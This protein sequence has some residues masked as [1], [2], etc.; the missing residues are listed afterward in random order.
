VAKQGMGLSP[1]YVVKYGHGNDAG[2]ATAYNSMKQ[3]LRLNPR[4]DGVF[5]CDDPIAMGALR[6]ILDA[7]LQIPRDVAVVG[8]GNVHYDDL[9][10]VPLTSIDQDSNGL[11]AAP[12]NWCSTFSSAKPR[13][14]PRLC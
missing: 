12:P 9:L 1:E 2:D 5:C 6:A 7:G 4:P 13:Q 8:C 11:G 10:R 14:P 3:L